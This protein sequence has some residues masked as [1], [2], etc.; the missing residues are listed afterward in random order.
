MS[1]ARRNIHM[2]PSVA[3]T[4]LAGR[5]VAAQ[6]AAGAC[7]PWIDQDTPGRRQPGGQTVD[8]LELP[9]MRPLW[10][11]HCGALTTP[12][13][14]RATDWVCAPA[15]S[16]P[17]VGWDLDLRDGTHRPTRPRWIPGIGPRRGCMGPHH[18]LGAQDRLGPPRQVG[19]DLGSLSVT[20]GLSP[21]EPHVDQCAAFRFAGWREHAP[22]AFLGGVVGLLT[23][24]SHG[25][26]RM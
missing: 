8:A 13:S 4:A 20:S 19:N 21:S 16:P 17:A 3:T 2:S 26:P 10:V 18:H 24:L 9:A 6:S 25:S 22:T 11:G 15:M 7:P 23:V 1:K 12:S 5:A 14:A